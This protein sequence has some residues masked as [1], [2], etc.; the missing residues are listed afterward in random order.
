MTAKVHKTPLKMRPIVACCGTFMNDWSQWLDYWLQQ[1]K[2]SVPTYVKDSQQVLDEVKTLNLPPTAKLFTCDANAMY[3]NIDTDHAITVISWWLTDL[4]TR[5]QTPLFF[6]LEAVI[7]AMK[8]I[9]KNNIFEFGDCYFL[10]LLG[11]AM[12]TLS[13]IMWATIY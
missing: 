4:D 10:Q 6:P 12:G 8:I 7:D 5:H 3:N 2:S 1:L 13:A 9:M 11:T